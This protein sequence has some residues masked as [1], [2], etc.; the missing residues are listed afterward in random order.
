MLL[1]GEEFSTALLMLNI[2][3]WCVLINKDLR[4]TVFIL[5]DRSHQK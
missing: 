2:V 1:E 4:M 5:V 3:E